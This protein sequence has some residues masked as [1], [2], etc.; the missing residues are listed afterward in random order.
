[1]TS[2]G[3][4]D[5]HDARPRLQADV[6]GGEVQYSIVDTLRTIHLKPHFGALGAP[7]P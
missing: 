4:N 5:H 7:G 1:M 3:R 6:L 2:L